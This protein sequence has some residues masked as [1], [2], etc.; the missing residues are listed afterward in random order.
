MR[1]PTNRLDIVGRE[2]VSSIVSVRRVDRRDR[3]LLPLGWK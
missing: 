3:A 2:C 1:P